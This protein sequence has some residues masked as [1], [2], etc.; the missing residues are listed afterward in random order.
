MS[1]DDR[2][3]IDDDDAQLRAALDEARPDFEA[4]ADASGTAERFAAQRA[5]ILDR[6]A[7]APA[8]TRVLAF[9][10]RTGTPAGRAPRPSTRWLTAAAA[11]GLL[12][13]L[14]AGQ[15]RSVLLPS[16]PAI[17]G[18]AHWPA[19]LPA[20]AVPRLA[21]GGA[22]VEAAVLADG[23]ILEEQFLR[24]MEVTLNDRGVPELRALD[25]LTPRA[26]PVSTRRGR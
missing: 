20:P 18:R 10:P 14:G 3:L 8:G 6:L 24:E 23:E 25:A 16:S 1:T 19:S 15:L 4:L 2:M 21:D 5:G 26:T 17:A 9:P 22:R 12:L 7:Q 11:A 13:G